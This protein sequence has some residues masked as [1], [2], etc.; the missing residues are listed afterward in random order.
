[1][2]NVGRQ[3]FGAGAVFLGVIGIVS[4]DFA[5]VWQPVP[6]GL[7]ARTIFAV[8]TGVLFIAGGILLCSRRW[9]ALGG[10]ILAVLWGLCVLLLHVPDVLAR[11]AV[12][13]AYAGVAEQLSLLCGAVLVYAAW[14]PLGEPRRQGLIRCAVIAD[15]LCLIMFGVVHFYY[16][17]GT[18]EYVPAWLPPGQLFWAYATGAGHIAA[19]ISLILGVWNR[20]AMKLLVL[21]FISFTVLIHIP[22]LLADAHS[23]MSWVMN[24]MNLCLIGAAW[25]VLDQ[26][27]QTQAFSVIAPNRV[28]DQV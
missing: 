15:A 12:V 25:V 10:A 4:R 8:I 1:M 9:A 22:L 2:T 19:G 3:V 28:S 27:A 24:A 16:G 6:Q 21:M 5:L 20:L 14:A 23:H 7:P 18:A 17:E 13:N 11:P 26:M